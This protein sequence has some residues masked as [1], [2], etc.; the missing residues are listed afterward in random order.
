MEITDQRHVPAVLALGEEPSKLIGPEVGWVPEPV[1]RG[2]RKLNICI[3]RKS[4]TALPI[5]QP[6]ALSRVH[7][8]EVSQLHFNTQMSFISAANYI[9]IANFCQKFG[10][11]CKE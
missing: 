5:L 9:R 6:T 4:N 7:K 8:T 2:K 10:K 1:K 3:G 11:H